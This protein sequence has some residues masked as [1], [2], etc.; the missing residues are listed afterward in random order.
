MQA[1]IPQPPKN[2]KLDIETYPSSKV[3]LIWYSQVYINSI[4]NISKD[5]GNKVPPYCSA[6]TSPPPPLPAE[7]QASCLD[8]FREVPPH[9]SYDIIEFIHHV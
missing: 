3:H 8:L 7:N 9:S 2:I 6:S 5:W 4:N 1:E